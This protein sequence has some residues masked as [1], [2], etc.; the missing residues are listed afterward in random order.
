[1]GSTSIKALLYTVPV[2]MHIN[3]S[4]GKRHR[5][6]TVKRLLL[7]LI[8]SLET[9]LHHNH[10]LDIR[11]HTVVK[12]I[13]KSSE[14]HGISQTLYRIFY[15]LLGRIEILHNYTSDLFPVLI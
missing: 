4:L 13:I 14:R 6:R 2:L 8:L 7:T 9:E 10:L 3:I 11:S 1:M 5:R 15:L 12:L